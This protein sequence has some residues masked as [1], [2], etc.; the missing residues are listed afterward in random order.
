MRLLLSS[1]IEGLQRQMFSG[2]PLRIVVQN[3]GAETAILDEVDL[4]SVH[5]LEAVALFAC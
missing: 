4:A 1:P 2:N 5:H 3:F